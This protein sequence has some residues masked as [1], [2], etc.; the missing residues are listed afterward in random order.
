M[1]IY[2]NYAT[3][4]E[5]I[6]NHINRNVRGIGQGEARRWKYKRLKFW[7]GKAYDHSAD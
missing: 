7:G 1:A 2:L 4:A 6:L 5:V 3:Q